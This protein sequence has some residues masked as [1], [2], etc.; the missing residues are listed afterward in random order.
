MQRATLQRKLLI[1]ETM[2]EKGTINIY[3]KEQTVT[4]TTIT[5]NKT[6]R[7]RTNV[8]AMWSS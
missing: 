2:V 3:H 4:V 1:Y 6:A 8:F 5:D 7:Q